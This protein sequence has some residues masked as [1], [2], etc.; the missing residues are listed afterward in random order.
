MIPGAIRNATH[1]FKAPPGTEDK[2]L[3]LHV[4]VSHHPDFGRCISS[5]WIPNP[6]ELAMLNKGQAVHIHLFATNQP[7]MSVQVPNDD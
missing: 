7:I 1:T 5:A 2:C 4:R 6:T 3:D